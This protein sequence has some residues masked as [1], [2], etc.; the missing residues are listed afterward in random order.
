MI[1]MLLFLFLSSCE[2][3]EKIVEITVRDTL[4]AVIVQSVD[5]NPDSIA[6]GGTI[7]FTAQISAL[8][9][10]GDINLTWKATGGT[11]SSTTGDTVSWKAP[12]APGTYVITVLADDGQYSG[13]GTRNIG[14][15]MYAATA[16]V[17][18]V[19][20]QVCA[21]CHS[22][23]QANDWAE[24]AHAHAWQT[25]M[26]SGHPRPTCNKCHTVDFEEVVGNAGY[27][28][29]PTA[30]FEDVQCE[31]CH[32]PGSQ[33][34]ASPTTEGSILV[35]YDSETT[36][37]TCHEGTHHPFLSEWKESAH[38]Q[39]PGHATSA[40][41]TGCHEG[42]ASA[43][44]LS[45]DLSVFYGSGSTPTRPPVEEVPLSA[46]GCATCHDPHN[47][48]NPGQLRTVADVPLTS[49]NGESPVISEGGT[50]KLCMHCHHARRGPDS[51]IASG[52]G[53]FG[54]HGSPQ[55]DLLAGKTGFH[56]VADGGFEWA[57]ASH[58]YVQNS[59]KTCHVNMIE[60]DGVTA[61]KGHTYEPTTAACTNCHGTINEFE[62]IMAL[63]DFDGNTNIEGVQLEVRGLLELIASALIDSFTA[64]G[65]TTTNWDAD[66]LAHEIGVVEHVIAAG[67]TLVVPQ[68]WRA[69]G[70]NWI[71]ILDDKSDGIHNP[72]Y[73][74]Q[75]LQQSY[76]YLTGIEIQG[77]TMVQGRN[78]AVADIRLMR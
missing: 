38:A 60:Y 47:A 24:T 22:N 75:L 46:I 70:W 14:V 12:E 16:D 74:V 6:I 72:D 62:D 40:S 11:F 34:I 28:D 10:V 13:V 36:C 37:G 51:Q 64:H 41:C 67:D 43:I 1:T 57:D 78:K 73:T 33:H 30:M 4:F 19:G 35:S 20:G 58:L 23:P 61:V 8:S 59:C 31:S 42:V 49:A 68:Q 2:R 53:H 71:F 25:L 7:T 66:S 55:A 76:R 27:D 52:Y 17:F 54:P 45:G 3:D 65:I 44:R 26:E 48:D 56:G 18:Y 21:N 32:G 5:A 9:N 77:A 15:G 29:V 63:G 69:A 39:A 50:G